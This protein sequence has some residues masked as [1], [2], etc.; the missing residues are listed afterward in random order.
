MRIQRDVAIRL[1]DPYV[2]AL[3]EDLAGGDL[4]AF[5]VAGVFR[6]VTPAADHRATSH[7]VDRS[8]IDQVVGIDGVVGLASFST[9][10]LLSATRRRMRKSLAPVC[11]PPPG[12]WTAVT[13]RSPGMRSLAWIGNSM[14]CAGADIP[15]AKITAA[16]LTPTWIRFTFLTQ[17]LPLVGRGKLI[18]LN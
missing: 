16:S 12:A 4:R 2:V 9:F 6:R 14:V 3:E 11:G 7:R 17:K 5:G 10:Q 13:I 8:A 18:H 1:L 15:P